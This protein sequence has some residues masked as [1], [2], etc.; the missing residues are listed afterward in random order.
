MDIRFAT[1]ARQALTN[2]TL[3]IITAS[4]ALQALS[5]L[6]KVQAVVFLVPPAQHL[7][8]VQVLVTQSLVMLDPT[9]H[10]TTA[11]PAQQARSLVQVQLPAG[12]VHQ[13]HTAAAGNRRARYAEQ[14]R[15]KAQAHP[16]AACRVLR[17]L[18]VAAGKR[19]ARH[20]A[21]GR[22]KA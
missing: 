9:S 22:I 11:T 13:D 4:I 15:I 1:I 20:A 16:S 8:G 19:H 5:N 18:T 17:A 2:R 7:H 21:Q 3:A 10:Q 14:G 12:S 6:L